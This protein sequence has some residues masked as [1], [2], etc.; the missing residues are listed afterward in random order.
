M[1]DELGFIGITNVAA[2][3][4]EEINVDE[5]GDLPTHC[6]SPYLIGVTNL[7]KSGSKVNGSAFSIKSIDLASPGDAVVTTIR[8]NN[9]SSFTG[10]SGASP[11]VAGAIGLMYATP[12]GFLS[13]LNR[14]GWGEASLLAK[15][16]IL[17]S[18][19]QNEKITNQ[20]LTGGH[21]NI[22][23]AVNVAEELC[24]PCAPPMQV[25]IEVSDDRAEVSWNRNG[26]GTDIRYRVVG[27]LAWNTSP[28]SDSPLMVDQ[29]Q[30]CARY[31]LQFRSKCGDNGPY[32]HSYYF[33]TDNCCRNPE[34]IQVSSDSDDLTVTWE[35]ITVANEYRLEYKRFNDSTWSHI[36]TNNPS[37]TFGDLNSCSAYDFR[38]K[39]MCE[40]ELPFTRSVNG[41]INCDQCGDPSYCKVDL[42]DNSFEFINSFKVDS[43]TIVTGLN[44]SGYS[45]NIGN[46][47]I[48]MSQGKTV[49]VSIE[50]GFN[51][52]SFTEYM[53]IYIDWNQDGVF[54]NGE[55]AFSPEGSSETVTGKIEVPPDALTGVT[56]MRVILSYDDIKGTC[57]QDGL[58]F[59]EVEDYCITVNASV[60]CDEIV[61]IESFN[62][63]STSVELIWTSVNTASDYTLDY[64][65]QGTNDWT[66]TSFITSFGTIINLEKNTDY[67]FR[68]KAN[69]SGVTSDFSDI[70]TV[71]TRL[72]TSTVDPDGII[73]EYSIMPNPFAERLQV[74]ID[75]QR[76]TGQLNISL[77]DINGR[78]VLNANHF[79]VQGVLNLDKLDALESGVY[80]IQIKG[81]SFSIMDKVLKL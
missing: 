27:E 81:E 74:N 18:V 44:A 5:E 10:T 57:T 72:G 61:S 47:G 11:L 32:S 31:E 64:R 38:V 19:S 62:T 67:E 14:D 20:V 35:N 24:N 12:C 54:D 70:I 21:L 37:F 55:K 4:N 33:T 8:N 79:V 52:G 43:V 2:T 45:N 80:L 60:E 13:E 40:D 53:A 75:L 59:G 51:G 71:K 16:I 36:V 46:S 3:S 28:S 77:Y 7:S 6:N 66:S 69:C 34:F 49:E 68:V 65:V 23:N 50:P 63:S 1:Y 17:G 42:L 15:D 58:E 25:G 76:P 41:N 26:N 30:A 22:A 29:L 39:T 9:Y 56:R 78:Q 73:N 48:V